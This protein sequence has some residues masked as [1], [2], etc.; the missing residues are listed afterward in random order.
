[1]AEIEASLSKL[2]SNSSLQQR[3]IANLTTEKAWLNTLIA[4]KEQE[5]SRLEELADGLKA[6][7]SKLEQEKALAQ[8]SLAEVNKSVEDLRERNSEL[9]SQIDE[10]T[11]RAPA[12]L[13]E[14]NET[15]NVTSP[16][17]GL[18]ESLAS[19]AA[20]LA[21]G[22]L[23]LFSSGV[24]SKLGILIVAMIVS[25][26]AVSI[27]VRSSWMRAGKG[28]RRLRPVQDVWESIE[29]KAMAP[30]DSS[31]QESSGTASPAPQVV[32]LRRKPSRVVSRKVVVST[33]KISAGPVRRPLVSEGEAPPT[34]ESRASGQPL[35]TRS[36]TFLGR[37]ISPQPTPENRSFGRPTP[38]VLHRPVRAQPAPTRV[39]ARPGGVRPAQDARVTEDS[40]QTQ[41]H[42][43]L[44]QR[45]G[46]GSADSAALSKADMEYVENLIRLGFTK[47][48]EE[49]LR[50]LSKTR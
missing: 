33:R 21:G 40:A 27:A 19:Q 49:A 3:L 1:V 8:A 37:S 41:A 45:T 42:R 2:E 44:Q 13:V 39:P 17:P 30:T 46:E 5:I 18:V 22:G 12:R 29:G 24:R 20:R 16:K 31:G 11:K 35:G 25:V 43:G 47:E 38:L 15:Q 23:R 26:S 10:L 48:A 50:K 36:V 6:Q 14:G 32:F 7:I 34:A 9:L 28:R 4:A